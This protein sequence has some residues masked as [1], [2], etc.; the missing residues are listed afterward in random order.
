MW[1]SSP[2]ALYRSVFRVTTACLAS[3]ERWAEIDPN[4]PDSVAVRKEIEK[5]QPEFTSLL[6]D[7]R[8]LTRECKFL[9]L[10]GT[11]QGSG[12]YSATP[13]NRADELRITSAVREMTVA[14][15][16]YAEQKERYAA[17]P[18][19]V[20]DT[21]EILIGSHRFFQECSLIDRGPKQRR[22][23]RQLTRARR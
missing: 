2:T 18:R 23:T 12:K 6:D 16:E 7:L 19:W 8:R 4:H 14:V 9:Y 21:T 11:G 5:I 3:A 15:N 13:C 17:L 1:S 22:Q 10:Q 20:E